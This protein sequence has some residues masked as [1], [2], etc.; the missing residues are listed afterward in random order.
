MLNIW[1]KDIFRIFFMR[2]ILF[3]L[4][5]FCLY[6]S[7]EFSIGIGNRHIYKE[8]NKVNVDYNVR[9]L[10]PE[11]ISCFGAIGDSITAGYSLHSSSPENWIFEY[12]SES[13]SIGGRKGVQTFPNIFSQFGSKSG[14]VA[15]K[16]T[17]VKNKIV[18]KDLDDLRDEFIKS[19]IYF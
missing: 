9:R 8:N 11:N 18:V 15:D 14:C 13:F 6:I 1:Y 3:L 10:R 19:G 17:F 5:S 7:F 16:N 12:R 4:F 2:N